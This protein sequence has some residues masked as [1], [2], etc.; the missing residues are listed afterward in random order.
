MLKIFV[1]NYYDQN[2]KGQLIHKEWNYEHENHGSSFFQ[3]YL[4]NS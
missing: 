4:L 3:E 2:S 1:L